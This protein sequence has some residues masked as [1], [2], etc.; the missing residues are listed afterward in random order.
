[1]TNKPDKPDYG[2]T[3][4]AQTICAMIADGTTVAACCREFG[5]GVSTIYDR[6]KANPKFC[7]MMEEARKRG[8]DAIAEECLV[9]ADDGSQDRIDGKTNKE[10]VQRSRLRV[11]TRLKLLAKWH[12]RKYGE[13]LQVESTN[14]NVEIP[15]SDDPIEAQKAYEKLMKGG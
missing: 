7:E 15:M 13:K 3:I 8:Y 4:E 1:M 11:D 9:I 5:I 6:I 10:L 2:D 14:T 12:P